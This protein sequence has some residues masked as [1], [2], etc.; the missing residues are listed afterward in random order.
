[1]NGAGAVG[2]PAAERL[3]RLRISLTALFTVALAVG[4]GVLA[5]VAAHTDSRL[6]SGTLEAEMERR[7]AGSTRLLYYTNSG[8]LKLDGVRDDDLTVGTPEV[9]VLL[10]TGAQPHEIFRSRGPHL[11]LDPAPLA[12]VSH[13]AVSG[14]AS[15]RATIRDRRGRDVRLVAAPFYNDATE[16]PAGAV[17]SATSL[18]PSDDSHRQLVATLVIGCGALIVLAA[19]AGYALAGRSL[20]PAAR[21]LEQ[22]EALLAD[23]AHELRTPVAA[24]RA[25][26]EAG[27]LDPATREAA[28]AGAIRTSERM[29]HTVAA[30]LARARLE[31][32]T[33]AAVR[34]KLRLDQL[35]ENVAAEEAQGDEIVV[36]TEPSVVRGDPDLLRIA[37]RNLIDNAQRHGDAGEG[38]ARVEVSVSDS[39]LT[40]A[41][42]GS[43]FPAN[44]VEQ[45]IGRFRAGSGGN[46]GLGLSIAAWIAEAAGG[47][48]TIHEREGGGALV[49][50]TM[51]PAIDYPE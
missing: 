49:K 42:R 41:D 50:L 48:L 22:Q 13:E 35:A 25:Q 31:A 17:V 43:G 39:T 3:R 29:G 37:I 2:T 38:S 7:V 18:Q 46:T 40:V 32:G 27:Q 8:E 1:M 19:A 34:S 23:A 14:D 9:R 12:A 45:G 47:Q 26:L 15:I 28:I 11:L 24:I 21:G 20:R 6:R 36:R 5:L 10:G 44:L 51:Q 30:L 4:L 33:E 16:R